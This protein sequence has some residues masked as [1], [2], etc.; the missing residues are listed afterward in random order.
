[1]GN[2]DNSKPTIGSVYP[3]GATDAQEWAR[4]EPLVT[5]KQLRRRQLAGIPLIS[6]LPDPVTGERFKWEDE[7][8]SDNI[9]RAVAT[10]ELK[11]GLS[12][13]S[14]RCSEKHPFDSNFWRNFGYVKVNRRPVASVEKLAFTPANGYDIFALNPDWIEPG[15]FHKGQINIIPMVPAAGAQFI[16]GSQ[17]GTSGSAY[18]T[19]L[20]GMAWVPAIVM[21]EYTTGFPGGLLPKV[22]NELIGNLAAID[23]LNSIAATNRAA[24]YSLGID[25]MSQSVST[26]QPLFQAKIQH[27]EEAS[28]ELVKKLKNLYGLDCF[29]GYL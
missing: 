15:N 28:D 5:P 13:F 8:L 19:F 27:L 1:M 29:S 4:T 18:L 7:D 26:T 6:Y 25:G 17:G 11:T 9:D 16:T 22:V 21:V 20:S 3:T 2:Y 24:S 23:I 12:I 14:V 10:V